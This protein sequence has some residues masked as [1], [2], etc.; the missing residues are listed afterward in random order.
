MDK[1]SASRLDR[2]KKKND[3]FFNG[4]RWRDLGCSKLEDTHSKATRDSERIRQHDK[5]PNKYMMSIIP[6]RA[7]SGS[8]KGR[9]NI[10]I[11]KKHKVSISEANG[12]SDLHTEP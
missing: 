8:S 10:P 7:T 5:T 2:R 1:Q 9:I 6:L 11:Y 3:V 12:R 4:V